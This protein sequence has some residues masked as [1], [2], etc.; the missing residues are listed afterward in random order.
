MTAGRK[1]KADPGALYAFAHQF[2]WDF[3][4]LAEGSFRWR[5]DK[6]EY[7]RLA[8]D[9]DSLPLTNDHKL[10]LGKQVAEEV[11]AGK[12]KEGERAERL[13]LLEET[14]LVVTRDW[15]RMEA[16]DASRKQLRIP[17]E[18]DVLAAL[19]RARTPEQIRRVCKDALVPRT[20]EVEPGRYKQLEMPN[21]P[22]PV[23]SM[24]PKYLAQ[25]AAEFIAAKGDPRFPRS[26]RPT[27]SPKQWWF[28]SRALA[29]ALYGVEV[30]TAINL[31]GSKRPEQ[32]FKE[33]R[34]A[35]PARRKRK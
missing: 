3:K 17:G 25:Y 4:R 34:A 29:G 1:R 16:A 33:S 12:V 2:Y 5:L 21:W 35:K 23:G 15:A 8:A 28:L 26:S 14:D 6:K 19:L 11:K 32:T 10:R 24:L 22:I 31:V 13:R 20:I 9:A 27:T 18:P 7:E 30:R